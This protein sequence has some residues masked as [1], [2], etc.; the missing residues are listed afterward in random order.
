M[1]VGQGNDKRKRPRSRNCELSGHR[2]GWMKTLSRSELLPLLSYLF[3]MCCLPGNSCCGPACSRGMSVI[4][5]WTS[6]STRERERGS[7]MLLVADLGGRVA[8]LTKTT[9]RG[10]LSL[11]FVKM[12]S[13]SKVL[14]FVN[15][16]TRSLLEFECLLTE[17]CDRACWF[18]LSPLCLAIPQDRTTRSVGETGCGL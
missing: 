18:D 2:W 11:N 6:T 3:R 5:E 15:S 16:V 14:P 8:G 1:C 7:K 10:T 13:S 12:Q 4:C 17:C 9:Q